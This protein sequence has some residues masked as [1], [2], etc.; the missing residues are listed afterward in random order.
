MYEGVLGRLSGVHGNELSCMSAIR[1]GALQAF[2]AHRALDEH[3]LALPKVI[4]PFEGVDATQ[5]YPLRRIAGS[6]GE[7]HFA[8]PGEQLHPVSQAGC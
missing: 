7:G 8:E 3:G 1:R 4:K 6:T 5:G 2:M